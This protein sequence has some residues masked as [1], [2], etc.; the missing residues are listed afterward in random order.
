MAQ[1]SDGQPQYVANRRA[2]TLFTYTVA[3]QIQGER[4]SSPLEGCSVAEH[5]VV[6]SEW[7]TNASEASDTQQDIIGFCLPTLFAQSRVCRR[8]L[9]LAVGMLVRHSALGDL[10]GL[11]GCRLEFHRFCVRKRVK[12]GAWDSTRECRIRE[13]SCLFTIRREALQKSPE[14][15]DKGGCCWGLQR[16]P[17]TCVT[18]D[19]RRYWPQNHDDVNQWDLRNILDE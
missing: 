12:E 9:Y 3:M 4:R 19:V 2:S 13:T 8:S 7:L 14:A 6:F 11:Y 16:W 10:R 15:R 18:I 5:A 1:T 17:G